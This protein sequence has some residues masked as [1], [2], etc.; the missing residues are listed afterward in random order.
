MRK[1]F[2]LLRRR[3]TRHGLRFT[4]PSVGNNT[5]NLNCILSRGNQSAAVSNLQA[6]LNL[7]YWRGSTM[8]GHRSVLANRLSTDG[9]FGDRTRDAVAA[10]QNHHD[11]LDV[12]GSY[13]PQT[14]GKMFFAADNGGAGVCR[15]YGA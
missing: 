5:G 11:G 4:L 13:G 6:H 3:M 2:L 15:Q 9:I 7:C 12:D 1:N 10:V 8:S 14:R